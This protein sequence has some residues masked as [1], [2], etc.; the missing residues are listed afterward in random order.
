[1]KAKNR[2]LRWKPVRQLLRLVRQGSSP[3]KLAQ[4]VTLGFLLGVIP[5]F[6]FITPVCTGLALWW[7]LNTPL[8]L[9]VLYAVL[10]LQLALLFPF[11]R[12]GIDIFNLPPLPITFDQL[13]HLTL[14]EWWGLLG[15]IGLAN[16][17]A[18]GVWAV[19][20]I[21]GGLLIYF[22]SFRIIA[23]FSNRQKA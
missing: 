18:V 21:P 2:L 22:L 10:P 14:S 3:R 20:S 4:S 19:L 7:R 15:Q 5:A 11:F 8:S 17:T 23:A 16:L 1:M 9:A 6:G 12:L 13:T